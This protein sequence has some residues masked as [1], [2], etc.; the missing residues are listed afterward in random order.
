MTT[1]ELPER[2]PSRI[3][4]NLLPEEYLPRK[5]SR[6]SIFLVIAVLLLAIAPWPFLIMKMDVDADN[7]VLQQQVDSLKQDYAVLAA[8]AGE[9]A[10]LK[11][12]VD[13]LE[14]LWNSIMDDYEEFENSIRTWSEIMFDVL[15]TPRG[16]EGDLGGV[17]QKADKITI[18]GD[19]NKEKYVYEY[20]VML[21]ETGHFSTVEIKQVS[22]KEGAEGAVHSFKI[23]AVLKPVEDVQ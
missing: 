19:F 8:E 4:L 13:A 21:Y 15:Q 23:D 7:S 1:Q 5:T 16:A 22:Y 20:S 6:L 17:I 18:D 3:D 14:A 12:E 10:K 2:R 9:A 11:A